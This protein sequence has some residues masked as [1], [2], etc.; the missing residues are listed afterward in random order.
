MDR[1]CEY[2][3]DVINC[4]YCNGKSYVYAKS[5]IKRYGKLPVRYRGCKCGARWSTVEV[6]A[7]EY[8]DLIAGTRAD[9]LKTSVM[10]KLERINTALDKLLDKESL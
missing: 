8:D 4:P 10:F 1:E 2:M 7:E 3:S 5:F 9:E 6:L